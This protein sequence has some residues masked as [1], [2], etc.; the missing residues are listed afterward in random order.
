MILK[1]SLSWI[2]AQSQKAIRSITRF[3]F[4]LTNKAMLYEIRQYIMSYFSFS[5]LYLEA[6]K[7]YF[8]AHTKMYNKFDKK[9]NIHKLEYWIFF[10]QDSKYSFEQI[11]IF[12][13]ILYI[14]LVHAC[15]LSI[16]VFPLAITKKW[17]YSSYKIL[18]KSEKFLSTI[19]AN[20]F[21]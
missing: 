5:R 20:L 17:H 13:C 11:Y 6:G 19:K 16:Q 18:K 10:N 14:W 8:T 2:I 12:I 21:C 7:F 15:K 3:S 4:N 1:Y 9:L